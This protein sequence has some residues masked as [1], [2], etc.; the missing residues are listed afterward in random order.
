[1]EMAKS[2]LE[3]L[4]VLLKDSVTLVI[5]DISLS[6]TVSIGLASYTDNDFHTLKEFISA[7]DE[8]V[9]KSKVSGKSRLS[10]Y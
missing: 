8:A 3:R 1:M 4:L 2:I 5:K 6:A 7:A 10:T 9:Y